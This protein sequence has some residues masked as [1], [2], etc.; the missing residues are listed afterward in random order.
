M[1]ARTDAAIITLSGNGGAIVRA[2]IGKTGEIIWETRVHND[3]VPLDTPGVHAAGD[4]ND[5]VVV[6]NARDVRRL[7]AG[8]ISWHFTPGHGV[9]VAS[10]IVT[11]EHVYVIGATRVG[12]A[13]R[14]RIDVL[15]KRGELQATH[16][17]DV[18]LAEGKNG[19]LLLP[20]ARRT[21]IPPGLQVQRGGPH[22]AFLGTD[23]AVHA[24]RIDDAAPRKSVQHVRARG[25]RGFTR[26]LDVGLGDRGYFV[27]VRSDDAGEVLRVDENGRLYSAWEFEETAADAVYEGVFD[28][29]GHAY[30]LRLFFMTSQHL[31]HQHVYWADARTG[32]ERGQVT[33]MS[34]QYDHDLHG[35]VL[36]APFEVG[37]M[38]P[39]QVIVRAAL[40]TSSGA[41]H[42]L[43]DGEHHWVLEE[44]LAEV[45][46]TL[47][48]PLPDKNLGPSAIAL[49]DVS[50]A[51]DA[52]LVALEHESFVH[53]TL[54]HLKLLARVPRR[55]LLWVIAE[56]AGFDWFTR[57]LLDHAETTPSLR[58]PTAG[59]ARVAGATSPIVAPRVVP[60]EQ[61]HTL[62][63]DAFG[64]R[65]VIVAATQRGKVYG[66]ETTLEESRLLWQ[67]SLLG[68]GP[69]EGAPEPRVNVT[70]VV[71]TRAT[72]AL[73]D[74][75]TVPPLVAVIAQTAEPGEATE[76]RVFEMNPLTGEPAR[77]TDDGALL[78]NGVVRELVVL[79]LDAPDSRTIGALCGKGNTLVIYPPA[80]T[81]LAELDERLPRMYAGLAD[82]RGLQG[83]AIRR[84]GKALLQ[85]VPTWRWSLRAGEEVVSVLDRPADAVASF[86]RVA[87]DRTVLYKYLNPHTRL[88]T[89]YTAAE[90]AADV[91][92]LDTVTG[93]L[94]YHLRVPNV[95]IAEGV[96]TTFVENWITV[97]YSTNQTAEGSEPQP[98]PAGNAPPWY[99]DTVPGY[100]RRLIS[101]ELY[102]PEA[103]AGARASSFA[104]GTGGPVTTYAP[105]IA[106]AHSFLLPYGVL[107][108]GV[109]RTTLGVTTKALLV[110]TDRE[111]IVMIPRPVLDPRRPLGKPTPADLE[112]GLREYQPEIP[113]EPAWHL[114]RTMYRIMEVRTLTASPSLLESSSMVL[115]VGLDWMYTMASPSGQFDRLQG[116][117]LLSHSV[118]QQAPTRLD[119]RRSP[120]RHRGVEPDRACAPHRGPLV[121]RHY[122]LPCARPAC[123]PCAPRRHIRPGPTRAAA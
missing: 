9:H 12:S 38:T 77:G 111:N 14:P 115:G 110:A 86:G 27:G 119:D 79:P 91:Y 19:L 61:V 90:Q 45:P 76:T 36:A 82:A 60:D 99:F 105:P 113:D 34:F 107:A 59:G 4:V 50:R 23:R 120:D 62:V 64:F 85:T 118:L 80:H 20:W 35:N 93:A 30:I 2:V 48:V 87:G 58:Q 22:I 73:L 29:A 83:H 11:A 52:P 44:G 66:I 10:T 96:R 81:A 109:S 103:A 94:A 63:H 37:K 121:A 123:A 51:A 69:G 31:L 33:G 89:T 32:K 3:T 102:E 57:L 41:V 54:R 78:C 25:G 116:T 21:H 56:R 84:A 18:D 98:A 75:V 114:T 53:R 46:H 43:Q 24:V 65:Q 74:G 40:V 95:A 101:V 8:H 15:T 68:Y 88:V 47:L 6:T 67:R 104:G 28:R 13:W 122:V 7:R 92:L 106:Y 39:Y 71:L 55:V 100:T 26:I 17:I 42:L 5:L 16:N 97:Q 112:E 49:R 117:S 108:T 1:R 72:G 70:D